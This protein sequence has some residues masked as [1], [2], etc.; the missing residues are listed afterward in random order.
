LPQAERTKT[1]NRN[2]AFFINF[3]SAGTKITY[4]AGKGLGGIN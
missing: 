1:K 3:F 2:A 4:K